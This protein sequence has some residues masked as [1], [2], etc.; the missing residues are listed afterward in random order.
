MPIFDMVTLSNLLQRKTERYPAPR[1]GI[2]IVRQGTIYFNYPNGKQGQLCEGEFVLYS[3][4][5]FYSANKEIVGDNFIAE[6]INFNIDIFQQFRQLYDGIN[7][8]S[9]SNKLFKFNQSDSQICELLSFLIQSHQDSSTNSFAQ[10]HI[11]FALLSLMLEKHPQL[12]STIVNA[13][14][15]TVTQKVIN[16]I[17]SNIENDISLDSLAQH[18]GMSTATL[19]R[20]LSAEELSFSNLVKVK[21]IN[22]A[23]NQL[24]CC[25]KSITQIA[26]ESGFKSA[27][28]FSTAFKGLQG[29]TPK[30]FRTKV[31]GQLPQD[32][33]QK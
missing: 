33:H 18:I 25:S 21:R 10:S 30:Q 14:E 26:Y 15:L 29:C 27:A 20:R 4:S 13:S 9:N 24:R 5:E 17:D 8:S 3:S 23:A 6:S 32:S 11:A 1:N 12:F 22:H 2:F 7:I 31:T 16:Y 28:H 19:K